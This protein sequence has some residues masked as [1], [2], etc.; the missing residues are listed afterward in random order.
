ML[1][2]PLFRSSQ[3]V[4]RSPAGIY[5]DVIQELAWS[6]AQVLDEFRELDLDERTLVLF[7]SHNRP[8]LL[9]ETHGGS[10]S[11]RNQGKATTWDD[12]IRVPT[13]F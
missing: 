11:L 7:T 8:W 5:G 1:R 2:V 4:G 6:T 3:F 12:G 13:L 10:A 9:F